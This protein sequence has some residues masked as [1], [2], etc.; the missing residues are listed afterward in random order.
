VA[1][2]VRVSFETSLEIVQSST[3]SG[4]I[5]SSLRK[6]AQVNAKAMEN[7][8]AGDTVLDEVYGPLTLC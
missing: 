2:E 7:Y 8:D 1:T 3:F 4:A 6:V 5:L